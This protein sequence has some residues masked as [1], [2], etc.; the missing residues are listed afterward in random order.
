MCDSFFADIVAWDGKTM[1]LRD[2]RSNTEY[3]VL[4]HDADGFTR[5]I[6]RKRKYVWVGIDDATLAHV[7]W[8]RKDGVGITLRYWTQANKWFHAF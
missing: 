3:R 1:L 7:Q 4:L 5:L 6:G 2:T 8:I